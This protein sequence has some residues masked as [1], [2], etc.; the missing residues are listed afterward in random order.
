MLQNSLKQQTERK[1]IKMT[2]QQFYAWLLYF[3][4][5]LPTIKH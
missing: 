5:I 2:P 4:S 3:L 1:E